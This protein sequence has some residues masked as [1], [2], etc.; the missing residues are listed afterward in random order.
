MPSNIAMVLMQP[1]QDVLWP[2]TVIS[3]R[4]ICSVR[5]SLYYA[6]A[7]LTRCLRLSGVSYI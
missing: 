2:L 7:F 4:L 1:L 3:S 5:L 6:C